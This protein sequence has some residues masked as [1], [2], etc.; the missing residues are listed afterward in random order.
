MSECQT[1]D[2]IFQ[3]D[4]FWRRRPPAGPDSPMEAGD[5]AH[6]EDQAERSV[7]YS[8]IRNPSPGCVHGWGGIQS[9]GV[10]KSMSSMYGIADG[11]HAL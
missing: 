8:S 11:R 5:E 7:L 1:D 10:G 3:F 9:M 6:V 4:P 2:V